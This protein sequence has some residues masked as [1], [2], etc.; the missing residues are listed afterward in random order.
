MARVGNTYTPLTRAERKQQRNVARVSAA[1]AAV[2]VEVVTGGGACV[3][4]SVYS[5]VKA[6]AVA[7]H[8][9]ERAPCTS[10]ENVNG[11]GQVRP[12]A[13]VHVP[14]ARLRP[15]PPLLRQSTATVPR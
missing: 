7:S 5:V 12:R 14:R 10:Y 13:G 6:A 11:G 2:V 15:P 8:A 4:C 3:S 9:V 1:A